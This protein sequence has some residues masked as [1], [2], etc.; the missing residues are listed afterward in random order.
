MIFINKMQDQLLPEKA[1]GLALPP[2]P[3]L[4]TVPALVSL[5]LDISMDTESK[6]D[7]LMPQNP[8]QT[9]QV[10]ITQNITVVTVPSTDLMTAGVS[11]SQR[12]RREDEDGHQKDSKTFRHELLLL[13]LKQSF[14]DDGNSDD[15]SCLLMLGTC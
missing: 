2:N 4:L 12:W 8:R 10:S 14:S 13:I 3:T 6:S 11:C 5:L 15:K 7:Q 9:S 1:C